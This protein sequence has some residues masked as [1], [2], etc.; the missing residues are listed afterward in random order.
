MTSSQ[1]V[2]D[3]GATATVAPPPANNGDHN[4]VHN[5]DTTA[6]TAGDDSKTRSDGNASCSDAPTSAG[7]CGHFAFVFMATSNPLRLD[8]CRHV[9]RTISHAFQ[10][11]I[12]RLFLASVGDEMGTV[13]NSEP[14]RWGK[15]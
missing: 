4:A 10:A 12:G 3:T 2:S 8:L 9:V 1:P 5:E 15:F 14:A 11:D 7:N 6:P 13:R